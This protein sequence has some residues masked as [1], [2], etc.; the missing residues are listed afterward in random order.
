MILDVFALSGE[1]AITTE[2][3]RKLFE[4]IQ[5]E[6]ADGK[7][8]EL[9]FRSVRV[10]ASPF[11]N[12]SIGPLLKDLSANDLRNRIEFSHLSEVGTSVLD[13]VIENSEQYYRNPEARRALDAIL[14][15]DD[16]DVGENGSSDNH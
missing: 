5:P 9:D 6:L 12:A 7:K 15:R 13:R 4:I 11:F 2:D 10:F 14:G 16:P 8:I 3:G 1:Y